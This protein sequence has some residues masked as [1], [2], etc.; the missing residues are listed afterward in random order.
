MR[1]K[2]V[3]DIPQNLIRMEKTAP[4]AADLLR[5]LLR[6]KSPGKIL[7]CR[8]AADLQF[9]NTIQDLVSKMSLFIATTGHFPEQFKRGQPSP[10]VALDNK[11]G[12]D[13]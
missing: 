10:V 7:F 1:C 12:F 8:P 3:A 5:I 9:P 4:I 2:S 11:D 6:K 13:K